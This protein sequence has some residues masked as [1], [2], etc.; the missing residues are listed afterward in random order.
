MIYV[1][2]SCVNFE[3]IKHSVEY[4]VNKGIKNIELSGGTKFYDTIVDDL[5]ILKKKHNINF[6]CH[7]Y[8]PPPKEN[9]FINLASIN[10]EI[11]D[12]SILHI[13]NSIKFCNLLEIKKYSFHAGFFID[14]KINNKKHYFHQNFIDRDKS[15]LRFVQ[16]FEE[17]KNYNKNFGIELYLENNVISKSNFSVFD[18]NFLMLTNYLEY[19]ELKK[20]ID[21]EL[22]LD[23]AHLKVSCK[24]LN[25]NFVEE[26][27][28]F[29]KLT[30]FFHISDN[31]GIEDINDE[32][33]EGSEI[34]RYFIQNKIIKNK[35]ITVE[36][37]KP[38]QFILSSIE[39][40]ER[41]Y[42]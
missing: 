16:A 41:N 10:D 24:T 29:T 3:K 18:S 6:L 25:L 32:I 27:D 12:K 23:V 36:I 34:L 20:K 30:D 7:N 9:F 11:F 35:T 4:L 2:S 14:P 28:K 17:I 31:D 37:Y 40:L 1:S 8:F 19:Q 22:L 38:I 39:L 26:L 42:E 33:V 5:I 21:F 15:I 13:K